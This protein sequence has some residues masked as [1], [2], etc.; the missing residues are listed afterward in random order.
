[1]NMA[2]S[3]NMYPLMHFNPLH[4]LID[5]GLWRGLPLAALFLAAAVRLR[6]YRGLPNTD[7][8]VRLF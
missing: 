6:R 7:T 1:M 5:P 2:R 8:A 4:N 3:M